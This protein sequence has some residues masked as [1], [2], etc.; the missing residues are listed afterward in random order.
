[1]KTHEDYEYVKSLECECL[2]ECVS[3]DVTCSYLHSL[4]DLNA[5]AELQCLY[6]HKF[7]ECE[8]LAQ[9]FSKQT[10]SVNKEVHN[11]LLKSFAKLENHSISLELALQ[12][13][14]SNQSAFIPGRNIQDNIMLTQ[15]IMK[16]YNRKGGP[17][18]VAIKIDLQKAYDTINWKFLKCTLKEFGF[19]VKMVHWIM[20]CV[21]TAGF[22]LNVNGKR[23][24][25][26]K[27]GRGIR[28]GDPISLYLFTLIMEMFSLML[29]RQI[30]RGPSFQYHY[31]C[32]QLKLLHICFADDLLVM[33]HGDT[34]YI[35]VIKKSLN[36]FS[37]CSRLMPNNAK[38]TIFFRSLNVEVKQEILNV[39]PFEAGKLPMRY[40]GV[41][42][43]SKRLSVKDCGSLLDKI[44]SKVKN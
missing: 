8:C 19:H 21:S 24:G 22:T 9:K 2:E 30:E 31:G 40:L 29:Q 6:L 32:K 23:I 13:F 35:R 33:C 34:N 5:Y 26:F 43:I 37:E 10:E 28:Q 42:L 18:R 7:K 17:K 14:S 36:E 3:K 25:Y 1:M 39:L 20:E 11:K 16:G 15:E 27:G 38:S 4:S 41:P 44:K 12:Q